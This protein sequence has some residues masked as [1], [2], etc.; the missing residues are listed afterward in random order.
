MRSIIALIASFPLAAATAFQP[1]NA[2]T[3]PTK[4]VRIIVPTPA[5][6]P[7]DIVA[8]GA[9]QALGQV[10]GQAFVVENRLGVES[11]IGAE[12]CARSAPDGH[13][14]CSLDSFAISL[15]P[16]VR[17][18]LPYNPDRDLTPVIQFGTMASALSV[19]AS[20][21]VSSVRELFDLVKAK[22]KSITFGSFGTASSNN[23]YIE[24]LKNAKGIEFYNVPYKAASQAMQGLLAGDIQ[25]IAFSLGQ[26]LGHARAGKI[27]IL[28]VAGDERS[29]LAPDI[30]S[31]KEAGMELSIRTWF[32]LFAPS[33][34]PREIVQRLNAEVG[35]IIPTPQFKD[36]F[37]T[38]QAIE[39]SG[40]AGKP[41]DAFADFLKKEREMYANLVKLIGLKVD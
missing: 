13:T 28:A 25:V 37:L 32:G 2:Q 8:R 14:L 38:T 19:H 36:K 7:G 1:A 16:L 4:P 3:Y 20:V 6:G 31:F 34:T 29:A 22:P 23:M 17:S 12:A 11:I 15:N 40:P 18:K 5:G 27:R 33:A 24:W 35:R 30:P 39:I 21:P 26:S 10:L 9:A 41:T